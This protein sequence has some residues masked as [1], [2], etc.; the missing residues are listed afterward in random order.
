MQTRV[1]GATGV[2]VSTLCLGAMAFGS[3]GN[4]D[5]DDCIRIIHAALDAGINT[6]D[7]ANMYS[8]GESE[9][10]VGRALQGRSR[11]YSP[12]SASGR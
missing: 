4:T 5:P 10:I 9:E 11:W 7:T 12:P 3:L 2:Q 6:I 1:L 8:K